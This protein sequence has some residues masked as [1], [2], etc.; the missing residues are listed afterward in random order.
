MRSGLVKCRDM[1]QKC[2]LFKWIFFSKVLR[3]FLRVV[4]P[5]SIYLEGCLRSYL[6]ARKKSESYDTPNKLYGRKRN[7]SL[8]FEKFTLR[9]G[10][11]KYRAMLQKAH[12]WR[13]FFFS[14]ALRKFSMCRMTMFNISGSLSKIISL[15]SKKNWGHTTHQSED[16]DE[17][18]VHIGK[19]PGC[20]RLPF[21]PL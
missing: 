14:N 8:D 16:I 1:L 3:K 4:W 17:N 6:Y 11:V 20:T 21:R 2:N 7:K 19:K 15:R 13:Q 18:P 9:I 12:F 5:C 10:L